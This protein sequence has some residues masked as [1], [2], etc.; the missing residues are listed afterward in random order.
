MSAGIQ[1]SLREI[2]SNFV[3]FSILLY[4][5]TDNLGIAQ[6]QITVRSIDDKFEIAKDFFTMSSCHGTTVHRDIFNNLLQELEHFNLP[7]E[8]LL[9]LSTVGAPAITGGHVSLIGLLLKSRLL[10]VSPIVYHCIF[11]QDNLEA[12]DQKM[13]DGMNMLV[14]TVNYIRT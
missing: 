13:G 3:Y 1:C 6:H 5:S 9:E 8:R 11:Y 7:L 10:V 12:Q 14:S 4:E 2:A